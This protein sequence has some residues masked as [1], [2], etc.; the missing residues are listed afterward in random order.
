MS[1]YL[2]L[3]R[4]NPHFTRLWLSQV[5]SMTGDWF[6]TVVLFALVAA[7]SPGRE[8]V[9]VSLFVLA[10]V[11]PPMLISPIT[12]VLVDRLNR[13]RL[14]IWSNVLRVFV[15]AALLIT[16]Q[17][18]EWLWLIYVLTVVQFAISAVFEPAQSALL[19]MLVPQQDLIVAN[20]LV[21]ITW[22]SMLAIGAVIG[23]VVATVLGAY[24]ALIFDALSFAVA[25]WL[26]L[27]IVPRVMAVVQEHAHTADTSFRDGLRFLR[28]RPQSAMLLLAK[29][30]MS[31]GNVDTLVAIY[32]TQ[33]FVYGEGGGLGL[34][35]MYSAFGVGA[36]IGPLIF[37]RFN[38][39]S[40][41]VMRRLMLVAFFGAVAGWL[42][43]GSASTFVLL[44]LGLFIRAVCGSTNWT[45]STIALQ[46]TVPNSY[47]GR[48]FSLD[49]AGFYLATVIS[50]VAHGWLI[51]AVGSANVR[52][53][54]LGTGVV[55]LIPA[56]IWLLLTR[57]FEQRE[58]QPAT[59]AA[60]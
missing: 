44:C 24:A 6:N 53:I 11:V 40:I 41:K 10:R 3:L 27:P 1:R 58:L 29:F 36:V 2:Q 30:G 31:L 52:L 12:G 28:S 55:A 48:V 42:T 60:D 17:G 50:T 59:A 33:I 49:M 51:D 43:L 46:K 26:V 16:T 7:Y 5:I 21:S 18:P 20:T 56:L 8:G 39:G 15:V 35:L 23:G 45:Y 57:H 4:E 47:L 38:D 37:N 19:P 54:A 32:A 13:K 25:A 14:L 34:G 9:A 22:S